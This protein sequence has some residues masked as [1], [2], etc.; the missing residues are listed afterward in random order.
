MV[1]YEKRR[2][3]MKKIITGISIFIVL[4]VG[5]SFVNAYEYDAIYLPLPIY[6]VS[7]WRKFTSING[8]NYFVNFTNYFL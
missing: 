6:E 8:R 5:A 3:S 2:K 1:L 4:I 7:K